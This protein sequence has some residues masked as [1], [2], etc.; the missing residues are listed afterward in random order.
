ME[1]VK[2]REAFKDVQD[3]SNFTNV[4]LEEKAEKEKQHESFQ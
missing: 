4:K 2:K 3:D 1:R